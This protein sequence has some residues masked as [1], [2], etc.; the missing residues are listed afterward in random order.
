V[1]EASSTTPLPELRIGDRVDGYRVTRRL[2]H[3]GMATVYEVRHELTTHVAALKVPQAGLEQTL[4]DRFLAEATVHFQLVQRPHIVAP[5]SFGTLPDAR[6]YLVMQLVEGPTLEEWL[7]SHRATTGATQLELPEA[8]RFGIQLAEGL[9]QAHELNPPVIHRDLKPANIF[10]ESRTVTVCGK[11][12]PNLLIGDFGL[13]WRRGGEALHS[14]TPEYVSPEQAMNLEPTVQ[15]DLYTFGVILYELLEGCLPIT[16]ADV[17]ELVDAHR[18]KPPRPLQGEHPEAL[19][20]LVMRLLEKHPENRPASARQVGSRLTTV[21]DEIEGRRES[22][23]VNFDLNAYQASRPT[24]QLPPVQER[25]AAARDQARDM[26]SLGGREGVARRRSPALFIA[27]ALLVAVVAFVFLRPDRKDTTRPPD[28]EVRVEPPPAPAVAPSLA[29]VVVLA[30][31][32][33][34]VPL[35][36]LAP[37]SS[38]PV[39]AA[40]KPPTPKAVRQAI[41]CMPDE[42]WRRIMTND[43]NEVRDL[44]AAKSSLE[45]YAAFEQVQVG[46]LERASR[47][48]TPEQCAAVQAEVDRVV[49]KYIPR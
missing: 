48:A 14:G 6:P 19:A 35:D 29:A 11:A 22:T 13:A 43:L 23:Q 39:T 47:A 38:R 7:N 27:L 10:V 15:S 30:P 26:D 9:A 12:V 28:A 44:V 49:R 21:L 42:R 2:G 32:A 16:G 5:L 24:D 4:V 40:V 3:G 8:L 33:S 37:L 31:D 18:R 34:A 46:I 25:A 20:E 17:V 41:D 1:A 36:D 45:Q